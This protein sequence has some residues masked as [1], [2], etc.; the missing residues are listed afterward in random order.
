MLNVAMSS[1]RERRG[2]AIGWMEWSGDAVISGGALD[3][4]TGHSSHNKD[5]RLAHLPETQL[6]ARIATLSFKKP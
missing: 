2:G 3:R 5:N 6:H 1:G 4:R